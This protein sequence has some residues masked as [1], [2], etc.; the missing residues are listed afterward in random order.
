MS[1]TIFCN[2]E[3][4]DLADLAMGRLRASTKGI[5]SIYYVTGHKH[6]SALNAV[7]GVQ[8]SHPVT[9][10]IVCTESNASAVVSRLVN[11]RAYQIITTG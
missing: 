9:V 7:N 5:K 2:F 8:P 6:G 1:A 4:Q 3:Q 10:K 11:L